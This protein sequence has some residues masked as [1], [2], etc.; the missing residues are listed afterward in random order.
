MQL[1][2]LIEIY[3]IVHNLVVFTLNQVRLGLSENGVNHID[4][5]AQKLYQGRSISNEVFSITFERVSV[6]AW[7]NL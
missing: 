1:H 2:L 6:N 3:P 7:I 5:A 4:Q